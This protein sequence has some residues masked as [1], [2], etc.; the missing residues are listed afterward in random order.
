MA[1]EGSIKEFGL[2]DIFQ[3]I[4]L[5]KKTGVLTL[6]GGGAIVTVQF[7]EGRVIAAQRGP[8]VLLE[9]VGELLLQGERLSR[10]DHARAVRRAQETRQKLARVLEELQL[11]TRDELRA[12]LRL[13]VT[14][15]I[16]NVFRLKEGRYS[17]QVS[18]LGYDRDY[19]EPLP[20]E[21][22]LME[23]MR[24]LD[25]WPAI[26]RV[27]PNFDVL[28][29]RT[30]AADEPAPAAPAES[31]S[32]DGDGFSLDLEAATDSDA[33]A[34]A[35]A[36]AQRSRLLDLVNGGRSLRELIVRSRLGE[37]ETCRL[38]AELIRAGTLR[39]RAPEAPATP[40]LKQPRAEWVARLVDPRAWLT[41][42][43]VAAVAIATGLVLP[44]ATPALRA[45]AAATAADPALDAARTD[46]RLL[47]LM[48]LYVL[49][50]QAL[51]ND[52]AALEAEQRSLGHGLLPPQAWSR[53]RF[54]VGEDGTNRVS[55]N[56][57]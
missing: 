40:V 34:E 27:L 53:L 28:I 24:R 56:E 18:P 48:E 54:A 4:H 14:E 26:E 11:A 50:R 57:P 6:E 39:V 19:L 43:A 38:T 47:E 51:P 55:W 21:H 10:P 52:S 45:V 46:A 8:G 16:F 35:R 42:A 17:F 32:G 41:L 23:A 25:E 36:T 1:L 31:G 29:E 5:Q 15:T 9:T 22:L 13:A 37:F 2:A 33:A 44:R 30:D 7:D 12:V 49:R 20:T 3:L